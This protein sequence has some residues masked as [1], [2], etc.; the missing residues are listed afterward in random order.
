L[1]V[2]HAS[3][4]RASWLK[5]N[6][7]KNFTVEVPGLRLRNA[8]ATVRALKNSKMNYSRLL[9]SPIFKKCGYIAPD[10]RFCQ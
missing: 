5:N 9:E 2:K 1:V 6:E 7:A 8:L 3:E 10:Q 4:K